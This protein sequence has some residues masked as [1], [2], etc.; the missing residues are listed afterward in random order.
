MSKGLLKM[1]RVL[2]KTLQNATSE[3]DAAHGP[4]VGG[5]ACLFNNIQCCFEPQDTC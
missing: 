5:S 1:Q 2:R 4:Y 3:E